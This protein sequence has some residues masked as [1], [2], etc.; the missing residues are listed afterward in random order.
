M[1]NYFKPYYNTNFIENFPSAKHKG[2]K[3]YFDLDYNCL[4]VEMDMEFDNLPMIILS[5]ETNKISNPW[6]FIEFNLYNDSD[7]TNMYDIF[8]SNS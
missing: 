1:I 3:Q 5:T 7:R 4:T 6:E 2:Y 8:V